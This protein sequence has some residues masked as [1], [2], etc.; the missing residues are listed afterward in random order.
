MLQIIREH[1]QGVIVW[2]IV[3][4][5][6]IT[7]ALFGLSSYLSGSSK[8]YV[9]R[10]N[11]VEIGENQFHRELQNYQSR[12]QQMLGKNF[13]ADMFNSEMVKQEVVNGLISRELMTQ[14]LDDKKFYVAPVKLAAEIHGIDAFKDEG[15]QFSKA[16]YQELIRRQGMSEGA[17]E[18]QLARDVASQFVQ[19]GISQSDF[20]TESEIQ[21]FLK[22]NNQQ[23][24]IGYLTISKQ[25]Y[26]KK[27]RATSE[28]IE[29]Y[30]D[31]H[32]NEFMNPEQISVEYVELDLDKLAKAYEITDAAIQ[33]QYDS[34]RQSYVSQPEQRRVSH[35]LIKVD[36]K[37]DEKSA[38]KII[39]KIQ[40]RL[41]KGESFSKLAKELS[42]DPGSAK[43]GGDLGFFGRGVMDKAFEES[44][45][46]L[47]KGEISKPVRSAFGYHL[48]ELEDIHAEKVKTFADV[49]ESIRKELQTQQA[50]Q[51]FYSLSEK[52]SNIT[53]E[54]PGSLQPVV[55]TLGLPIQKS[56]LFS[57]RGGKGIA[58]KQKVIQAA[59]SDE[60][61]NLGR[62]SDL[63]ELSDTHLLVLR[64][65]EQQQAS[66][67]PLAE[68]SKQI[69]ERLRNELAVQQVTEQL[70][71]AMQRLQ[72]G[73]S[74]AKL[75][76]S[77]KGARWTH[78]GL[79][80]RTADAD[81]PNK[82]KKSRKK[83]VKLDPQIRSK[84]FTLAKPEGQKPTW[85]K[86]TL[87]NGDGAVIGLYAIKV[88][89]VKGKGQQEQERLAQSSGSAL[90]GR[91]LE[92]QRMQA[93]IAINL[94]KDTE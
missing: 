60:V 15:G 73:E 24:D 12:L 74:P 16:R 56:G 48:I 26:L 89:E 87:A 7:F 39:N 88:P 13:Q 37:T 61:L 53:Y 66:Q 17:F 18:Q 92:Q 64:K 76:K 78:A 3:G 21:Q 86:V 72:G 19:S 93:K 40:K 51:T 42:Q 29:A 94:P 50:E 34:H 67:K 5:I 27:V 2:T 70:Q 32:K 81:K 54:Q 80:K 77:I 91:L 35:I 6:I 85:G 30:Y 62:N 84:V 25:P 52:L 41:K 59:F 57:R 65:L 82:S 71:K 83:S 28:Q 1:A 49:K 8:N 63:I 14:Y 68:V 22:L 9:A 90:F 47:K 58:A 33:Q 44:A 69:Q 20:A 38:L 23:R 55:D 10:I 31:S 4:L 79:I 11:G 75:A 45:F 46:S 43:Q 36:D